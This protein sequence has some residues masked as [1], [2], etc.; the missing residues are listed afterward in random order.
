MSYPESVSIEARFT[1]DP[2]RLPEFVERL[3]LLTHDQK[4]ILDFPT[5]D[6]LPYGN[7]EH[8]VWT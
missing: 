6:A 4:V 3:E 1:M 7:E 8:D 5:P 2:E